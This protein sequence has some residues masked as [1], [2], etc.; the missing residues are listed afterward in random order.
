[1]STL[2]SLVR[3]HNWNVDQARRRLSELYAEHQ[4]LVQEGEQ[5]EIDVAVEQAKSSD[6][7]DGHFLYQN[8]VS[9]VIAKR[10]SLEDSIGSLEAQIEEAM[11][12]ARAAFREMKR[13]EVVQNHQLEEE[14]QDA[15]RRTQADLDEIAGVI[16][17]RA[18]LN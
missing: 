6:M 17:Q 10:E 7:E 8:Y 14:R 12:V 9:S 2:E 5:L 15:L 18:Q 11:D 16:Y 3:L 4:K 1:M 13:V